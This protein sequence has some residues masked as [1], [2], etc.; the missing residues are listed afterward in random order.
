MKVTESYRKFSCIRCLLFFFKIRYKPNFIMS[1][2]D[3]PNNRSEH[4][5]NDDDDDDDDDDDISDSTST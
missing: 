2:T 3:R 5:F 4:V 1:N